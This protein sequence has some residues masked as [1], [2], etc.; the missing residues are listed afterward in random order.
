M[1]LADHLLGCGAGEV[2]RSPHGDLDGAT[3]TGHV[4]LDKGLTVAIRRVSYGDVQ[5]AK[6]FHDLGHHVLH[7]LLVGHI[8]LD[9]DGP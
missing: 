3:K 5:F 4:G 6:M 2:K 9:L 8:R 7:G 1:T